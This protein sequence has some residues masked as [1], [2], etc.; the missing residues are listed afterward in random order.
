MDRGKFE[1]ITMDKDQVVAAVNGIGVQLAQ[2]KDASLLMKAGA[3][4]ETSAMAIVSDSAA[5]KLLFGT[6]LL[7]THLDSQEGRKEF[8][9]SHLGIDANAADNYRLAIFTNSSGEQTVFKGRMENEHKLVLTDSLPVAETI[10]QI[11]NFVQFNFKTLPKPIEVEVGK[12]S[13]IADGQKLELSPE[14]GMKLETQ[15]TLA[16]ALQ[17]SKDVQVAS[18]ASLPFSGPPRGTGMKI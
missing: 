16:K 5:K 4:I 15:T 3:N 18:N 13:K 1:L 7:K 2:Y 6:A 8:L 12:S 9:K 17:S 14:Q 11:P 10:T